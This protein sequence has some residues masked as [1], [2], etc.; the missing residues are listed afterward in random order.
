MNKTIIKQGKSKLYRIVYHCLDYP[1][2]NVRDYKSFLIIAYNI[3]K[4]C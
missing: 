3:L 4:G 2:N 1:L